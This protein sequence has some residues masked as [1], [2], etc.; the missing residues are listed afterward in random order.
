MKHGYK[1]PQYV[2]SDVLFVIEVMTNTLQKSA[3]GEGGIFSN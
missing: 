3:N 2:L 1:L